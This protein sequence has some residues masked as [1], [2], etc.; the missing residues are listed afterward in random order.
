[1]TEEV[2]D[3][4]HKKA[5]YDMTLVWLK[6]QEVLCFLSTLAASPIILLNLCTLH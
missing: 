3:T 4:E 2:D 5:H 6:Q 1:M